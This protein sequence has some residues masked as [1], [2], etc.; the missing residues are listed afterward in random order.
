[1]IYKISKLVWQ[2]FRLIS[3]RYLYIPESMDKEI[4]S[5]LFVSFHPKQRNMQ[6]IPLM[7]RRLLCQSWLFSWFRMIWFD[8]VYALYYVYNCKWIIEQLNCAYD[9]YACVW[10]T[11]GSLNAVKVVFGRIK[12]IVGVCGQ[13]NRVKV[14]CTSNNLMGVDWYLF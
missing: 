10:R 2:I 12:F 13:L 14:Y 1:M 9:N 11:D 3:V 4:L 6:R 8:F 7:Q 5:P